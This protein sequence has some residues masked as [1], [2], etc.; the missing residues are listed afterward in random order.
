[1]ST[2]RVMVGDV[3]IVSVTDGMMPAHPS[4]LFSGVPSEMYKAALSDA[5]TAEGTLPIKRSSF[6]MRS[7]GR[8]ILV[9]TGIG[10]KNP[11]LPGGKVLSNVEQV[12]GRA[13]GLDV[14]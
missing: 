5:L 13:D 9:D 7:S 2:E 10:Y 3:E 14:V 11:Q 6:L 12:R 4:F 8:T 1:M